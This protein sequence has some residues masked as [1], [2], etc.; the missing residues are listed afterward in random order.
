MQVQILADELNVEPDEIADFDLH[1]C[2]TQPSVIA[3]ARN[4]FIYSGELFT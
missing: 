3:G 1:V 2:D 4:E